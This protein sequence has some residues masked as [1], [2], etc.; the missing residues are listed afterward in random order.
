M[1]KLLSSLDP[2][3]VEASAE[4][5]NELV[6]IRRASAGG[7]GGQYP[8]M[9]PYWQ[10]VSS[11]YGREMMEKFGGLTV[12]EAGLLPTG[13]VSLFKDKRVNWSG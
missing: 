7:I 1:T 5:R 13:M 4:I 11:E 6:Q 8:T 10:W 3:P 12:V 2:K 9:D